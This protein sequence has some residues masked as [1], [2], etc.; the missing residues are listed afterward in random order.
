M[1][2]RS[3]T[4]LPSLPESLKS[5]KT[6]SQNLFWSWNPEILK[7]FRRIDPVLWA[8]SGHNPAKMLGIVSQQRLEDL[9]ENKG[10][11][12][13]LRRA[14]DM[15][16]NYLK[17]PTWYSKDT[18]EHEDTTIA[19]FSAEFGIHE[20]L[21][22]YAGGLGILAGD[23]LKSASDL[24]LPL[25]GVGLMYQKGYFRQYLNIDGWQQEVYVSND[26]YNM[27]VELVR[28]ENGKPI[29]ITIDYPNSV[30]TA[31]IWRIIVGRINLYLL[32]TNIT[33]NS[34][35][36]RLITAQL[37]GGDNKMRIR[38]EILIGI[39]GL[40]A[41][42]A[43]NIEPQ[44]C[45]MNEG[46]AA[47]MAI[48]RIRQ[49]SCKKS[50]SFEHALELTRAGNVFTTHT[51]VT[52]GNDEFPPKL[53]NEY[54]RN[55]IGDLGISDQHFL[56]FGRIDP[57]DKN[58]TFKMSVLAIKLSSYR[59]GVS[60]L[61]GEVSRGMWSGLWPHLPVNEVPISSVTNGIHMK[62]WL[63]D[64][65]HTLYERYVGL[66][67]AS[68]EM[69][70]KSLWSN[71]DQI[72]DEEIWRMH[73]R[74]KT[75]L[76]SFSRNRLKE[77]MQRRGTYHT[78]LNWADEVLDPDALTIGFARRFATYKRGNLLLRDPERLMRLLSNKDRPIQIIFAGKAHPRDTEGKEI[79]RR[80]VHFANQ[81][82]VR[83]HIVFLEDYD[84]NVARFMVQG[85]DIWLNTP[86][87]P[88]EASGTSGMKAAIN[89][90]MNVS[91]LDGWWCEGYDS[92][93]G[94]AIGSGESYDDA[95]YQDMVE[96]Q[97]LYNILENEIVPL[98][99]TRAA[100]NLPRAWIH[101]MKNCI[102]KLTPMFNTDRMVAD[103][104]SQSYVPA[105]RR[106]SALAKDDMLI[107]KQLSDWKTNIIANWPA[108][109]IKK[110]VVSDD[111]VCGENLNC[112]KNKL[113]VGAVL[114]V[115]VLVSLGAISPDDVTVEQFYGTVDSWGNIEKGSL[116]K[117]NYDNDSDV[118]G[119]CWFKGQVICENSGR[120]GL[121]VR[122][123]PH[124]DNFANPYEMMSLITW[125]GMAAT[126]KQHKNQVH[127]PIH[128]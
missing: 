109:E 59:N 13:E 106:W 7:L 26:F 127:V 46:H 44:V 45:H 78:E 60:A 128:I 12:S 69:F 22:L 28:D 99:Y 4:V 125:E 110:V 108:V 30:V 93:I 52:A 120:Q 122:M 86:R 107:A 111:S 105:A 65:I 61:H 40:R 33:A 76:V 19:Y 70:D 124:N 81:Y 98:F 101:R 116:E 27:P 14:S 51:P 91:I 10:F 1:S 115:R 123:M 85:V 15:L 34:Y 100:D 8:E 54:F 67:W 118:E 6:I 50:I 37:Y 39:G 48:E 36:D 23:H 73:Q 56:S 114:H 17:S 83:R 35:E 32:D 58:E 68:G 103:Y 20:S 53:I 2:V 71:I 57:N 95:E 5:L 75:R 112:G 102:R 87:R 62:S 18:K 113:K 126:N 42:E 88:M 104:T 80:I 64:D 21:P 11:L 117:M 9:A 47:F 72:P 77:Q 55:Y 25:I 92:E 79:I 82:G 16:D 119:Q 94:W 63:P 66:N 121:T 3:F 97:A 89:G 29:T 41:L 84:I 49:A 31:Q 24:G 74:C 96:S 38:Q 90:A 43:M